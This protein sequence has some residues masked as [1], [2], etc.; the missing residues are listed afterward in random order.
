MRLGFQQLSPKSDPCRK[1]IDSL[2]LEKADSLR[3][4]GAGISLKANGW[5][6]LDQFKVSEELRKLAVP[7]NRYAFVS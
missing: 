6:A 2:V 5:R 1:G 3:A 7:L 4:T